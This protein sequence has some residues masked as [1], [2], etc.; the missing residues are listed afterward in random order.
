[1]PEQVNAARVDWIVLLQPL[2][3]VVQKVGAVH[4]RSPEVGIPRVRSDQDHFLLCRQVFPF[5]DQ[6]GT[7]T[8]AAVKTHQQRYGAAGRER[9]GDEKVKAALLPHKLDSFLGDPSESAP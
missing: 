8:A 5:V 9:F 6:G 1:M 4:R 7:V 3:D 2:Y